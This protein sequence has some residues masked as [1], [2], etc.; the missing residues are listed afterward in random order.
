MALTCSG[1]APISS[2]GVHQRQQSEQLQP[3]DGVDDRHIQLAVRWVGVG[4][5]PHPAAVRGRVA[6]RDEHGFQLAHLA[7]DPQPV[8]QR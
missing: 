4:T 3:A 6:D 8:V 5:D 2:P 1:A 7:V